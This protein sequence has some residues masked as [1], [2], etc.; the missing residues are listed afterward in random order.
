MRWAG[1]A[2]AAMMI[3]AC[4]NDEVLRVPEGTWGGEGA[5][6][7]VTAGGASATFRCGAHALVPSPLVLDEEGVVDAAGTYDPV[8]VR[9]GAVPA[10]VRATL[11]G[12]TLT[13]RVSADGVE[14]G[15]FVLVHGQGAQ[16]GVCNFGPS[17]GTAGS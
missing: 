4:G 7:I 15:P 1:M 13:L 3:A 9:T 8:L 17:S 14:L 10:H 12:D 16:L 6:L 11:A 2:V 5:E